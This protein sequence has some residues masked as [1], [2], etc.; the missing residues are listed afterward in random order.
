MAV[1]YVSD[2][3]STFGHSRD[4]ENKARLDTWKKR[5]NPLKVSDGRCTTTAK[6]VGDKS[7]SEAGRALLAT[8]LQRLLDAEKSSARVTKVFAA[9]RNSERDQQD[10][11]WTAEFVRRA[12]TII[13]ARCPK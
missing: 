4:S 8:Q 7:I 12:N 3:G 13:N 11:A 10:Q 9:S 5:S 6:G 1:F 2:M